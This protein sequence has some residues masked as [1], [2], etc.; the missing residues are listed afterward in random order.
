MTNAKRAITEELLDDVARAIIPELNHVAD[1]ALPPAPPKRPLCK[2]PDC[3]R[4][5]NTNLWLMVLTL[6]G[7][8]KTIKVPLCQTHAL[9]AHQAHAEGRLKDYGNAI[10]LKTHVTRWQGQQ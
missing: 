10:I 3:R 1:K 5:Y 2:R 8:R 4:F 7:E 6:D 9:E